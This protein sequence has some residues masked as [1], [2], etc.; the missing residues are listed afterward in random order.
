[1]AGEAG[2]EFG[3][4]EVAGVSCVQAASD[5]ARMKIETNNRNFIKLL[6]QNYEDQVMRTVETCGQLGGRGNRYQKKG[7]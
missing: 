7:I 3:A 4:A 5:N 2:V 1:L 6:Y